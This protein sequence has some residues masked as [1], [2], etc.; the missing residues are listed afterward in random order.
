M[1]AKVDE[2][3][4]SGCGLCEETCPEVFQLDDNGISR[5]IGDCEDADCCE[6]AAENCP[7]GA[8]TIE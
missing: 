4:C 8:I 6:E 2:N 1:P 7:E 3:L 5:V